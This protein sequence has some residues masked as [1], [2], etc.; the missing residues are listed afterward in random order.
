MHVNLCVD[1]IYVVESRS[2]F[3]FGE[4]VVPCKANLQILFRLQHRKQFRM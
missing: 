2:D 4:Y 3:K 1:F